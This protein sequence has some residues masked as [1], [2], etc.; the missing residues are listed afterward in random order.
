MLFLPVRLMPM[1]QR[2]FCRHMLLELPP[3]LPRSAHAARARAQARATRLCHVDA[4]MMLMLPL[5]LLFDAATIY[6][7][8]F[9]IAADAADATCLMPRVY[10]ATIIYF[11]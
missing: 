2:R 11:A 9:A 4:A 5:I 3:L 8:I 6:A 7:A 1:P 10:Y